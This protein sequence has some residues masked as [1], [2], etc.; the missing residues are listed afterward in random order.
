VQEKYGRAA[1][2]TYSLAGAAWIL[3][4]AFAPGATNW[5]FVGAGIVWMTGAAGRWLMVLRHRRRQRA[6]VSQL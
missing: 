2:V 6:A 5:V 1:A 3:A 4:G